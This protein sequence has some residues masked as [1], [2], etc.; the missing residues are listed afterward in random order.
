MFQTVMSQAL[1]FLCSWQM[2][3]QQETMVNP[4]SI[5]V[6]KSHTLSPENSLYLISSISLI[7]DLLAVESKYNSN[8]KMYNIKL[9]KNL[10]N[11]ALSLSSAVCTLCSLKYSIQRKDLL[12]IF[13]FLSNNCQK[14]VIP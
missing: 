4:Q 14:W 10:V 13:P 11:L 3:F 6:C 9:I 5:P 8:F 12:E 1:T 2:I 7:P